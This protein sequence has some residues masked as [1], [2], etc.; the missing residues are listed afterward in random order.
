[1]PDLYTFGEAMAL[2]LSEDTDSVIDAKLYRRSTAGAEGN[3]AEAVSRL[4]LHSHFYTH[5]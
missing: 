4:V 5:L 2:F 3:V 1:M